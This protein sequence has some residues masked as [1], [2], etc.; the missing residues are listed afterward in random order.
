MSLYTL[1]KEYKN[2]EFLL[3]E[4]DEIEDPIERK[5]ALLCVNNMLIDMDLD[6]S[7]KLD[8]TARFIRSL[9]AD[10]AGM[11][12]ELER[13]KKRKKSKENKIEFLK[14][15]MLYSLSVLDKT[16]I[17]TQLFEISIRNSEVVEIID[18]DAIPEEF[19]EI[20]KSKKIFKVNIKKA[21]KD[22]EEVSGTRLQFNKNINIR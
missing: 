17:E 13:L 7:Q 9:E 10:I 5:K 4:I 14:D 22:G 2:I 6:I 19:F 12:D 21:L 3:D 1:A 20:E 11:V 8:N 16:K 18:E 15:N